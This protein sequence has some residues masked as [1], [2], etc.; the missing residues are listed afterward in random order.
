MMILLK[1]GVDDGQNGWAVAVQN[2][3]SSHSQ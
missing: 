1:R 3:N 2:I